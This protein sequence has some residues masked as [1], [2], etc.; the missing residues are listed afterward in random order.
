M[1]PTTKKAADR[2][3]QHREDG[4]EAIKRAGEVVPID[5]GRN[6]ESVQATP[7]SENQK[8]KRRERE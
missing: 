5:A 8:P 3:N 1:E 4:E 2:V 7:D 6:R